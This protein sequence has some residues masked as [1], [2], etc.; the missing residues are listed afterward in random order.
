MVKVELSE[1]QFLLF[2]PSFHCARDKWGLK[3]LN[4]LEPQREV[5]GRTK[6]KEKDYHYQAET[7]SVIF[8]N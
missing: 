4:N 8:P 2:L 1:K 5:E 3:I 6:E 7:S